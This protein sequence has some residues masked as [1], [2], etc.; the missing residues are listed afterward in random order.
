VRD[1][2]SEN[3]DVVHDELNDDDRNDAFY[4]HR[5]ERD[6]KGERGT[7]EK[8][9]IKSETIKAAKSEHREA[10]KVRMIEE[11]EA[12]KQRDLFK[13][14]RAF[15][16]KD[17]DEKVEE[18]AKANT[19]ARIRERDAFIR[20][21][22]SRALEQTKQHRPNF[23]N[24]RRTDKDIQKA[25]TLW[26]RDRGAAEAMYGHISLWDTSAVTSMR[27][28]F[29]DA[30]DF[31]YDIGNWETG[32]VKDMYRIFLHA[33]LSCDI[34]QWDI[35]VNLRHAPL[36]YGLRYRDDPV[37]IERCRQNRKQRRDSFRRHLEVQYRE[38][39]WERR[40]AWVT[41][42]SPFLRQEGITESPV[43]VV[44]DLPGIYWL[45]TSF[46]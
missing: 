46:I 31:K 25:V 33:R 22:E 2:E 42:I 8:A 40:R 5:D 16:G 4:I 35:S 44:F 12:E 30:Y 7:A 19:T 37:W 6:E 41:V 20:E 18:R 24:L 43:Q 23:L 36:H 34:S 28:L 38:D 45:I 13:Q 27:D 17:R 32:N 3:E 11:D 1:G 29:R 21:K 9:L 10:Y 14:R 26:Q 15:Y 39:S